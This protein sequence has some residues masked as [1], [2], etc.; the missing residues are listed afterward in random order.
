MAEGQ[1]TV[2]NI[3]GEKHFIV[4]VREPVMSGFIASTTMILTSE[5]DLVVERE[6]SK[7]KN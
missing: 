3:F 1:R 4:V 2:S 6:I 7:I 5:A